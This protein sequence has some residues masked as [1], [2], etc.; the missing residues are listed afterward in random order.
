MSAP[1][2]PNFV[3][4]G[5]PRSGTTSLW[6]YLRDHPEVFMAPSKELRFFNS[7]AGIGDVDEYRANFRG[8]RGERAIGEASPQYMYSADAMRR[9]AQVL[10]QSRLVVVLRNPVDRAYSD[11]W[12]R[13]ATGQEL[14][15]FA[16]VVAAG[17]TV[18]V[19]RGRYL[20]YLEQ[21]CELYPRDVLR[22]EL[23]EELV[24]SPRRVYGSICDHLGVATDFVPA[25]L[26]KQTNSYVRFRSLRFRKFHR[27]LPGRLRKVVGRL[28]A[29]KDEY[30]EMEAS[31]RATLHESFADD[32]ERLAKWLG[33]D[34]SVWGP[35]GQPAT[36]A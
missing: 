19:K 6:H 32:N 28:N 21:V 35:E 1:P 25:E 13:A 22:V 16:E 27:R 15:S 2:L 7:D 14:R 29:T 36:R 8:W 30:P 5:A 17:G 4:I 12:L 24:S 10:P 23:F 34:L 20:Q 31:I 18:Y 9:M 3:V 26:G 11:Y 33:R